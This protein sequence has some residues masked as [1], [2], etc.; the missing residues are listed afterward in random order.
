MIHLNLIIILVFNHYYIDNY[1]AGI[2]Q[3]NSNLDQLKPLLDIQMPIMIEGSP[4]IGKTK[5][6]E[7]LAKQFNKE[8]IRIN[9]CE[10]TEISDL[11]GGEKPQKNLGTTE[12]IIQWSDGPLLNALK[13][14]HW[15]LFD[16]VFYY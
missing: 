12:C 16:E 4:G 1:K 7:I 14:K 6:V 11:I 15:I 10:E 13:N 8:V 5:T 2:D 9:F 3:S